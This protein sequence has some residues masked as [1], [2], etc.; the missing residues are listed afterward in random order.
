MIKTCVIEGNTISYNDCD[1]EVLTD[2]TNKA[3]DYL[4]YIGTGE[5]VRNPLGNNSCFKMF[6]GYDGDYLNLYGFD[7]SSVI[8][9]THMF[10]N[11]KNLNLISLDPIRFK[12]EDVISM[13]CMFSGCI[14]LQKV[15]ISGFNTLNVR[16]MGY[17]FRNCSSLKS[18]DL[19][20]FNTVNVESMQGMFK[21]CSS[22]KVV[23]LQG[24]ETNSLKYV[25]DMF[26]GCTKLQTLDLSDFN[27]KFVKSP[28]ALFEGCKSL[29]DVYLNLGYFTT[30]CINRLIRG[31]NSNS[32][33]VHDKKG[34]NDTAVLP[35]EAKSDLIYHLQSGAVSE[36]RLYPFYKEKFGVSD[37]EFVTILYSVKPSSSMVTAFC[38]KVIAPKIKDIF[39][40]SDGCSQRT[41]GEV[42]SILYEK[43]PRGLVNEALVSMLGK[44]Y[45]TE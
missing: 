21:G 29:K 35:Q 12:T 2:Y 3:R 33:M 43:Y 36:K 28:I 26:K 24:L 15:D 23:N 5:D 10:F 7:S 40:M 6:E 41:L 45:L 19:G 31:S 14:N 42:A 13:C 27:F 37:L 1:F 11:C 39:S 16:N 32:I 8:D 44:E 25:D 22:L 18:L 30:K 38:D 34:K 20:H 17:M 4:H 9:M